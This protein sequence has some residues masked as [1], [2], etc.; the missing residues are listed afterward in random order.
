MYGKQDKPHYTRKLFM[1]N[2]FFVLISLYQL[3]YFWHFTRTKDTFRYVLRRVNCNIL[4]TIVGWPQLETGSHF[5]GKMTMM[6]DE[7][8]WSS[9]MDGFP[10]GISVMWL[11]MVFFC[12]VTIWICVVFGWCVVKSIHFQYARARHFQIGW[13]LKITLNISSAVGIYL[14]KW[15]HAISPH[16]KPTKMNW[17]GDNKIQGSKHKNNY[18]TGRN[19]CIHFH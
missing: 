17:F 9:E 7:H 1:F 10:C 16:Y 6:T 13:L 5:I 3:K 4:R 18:M 19:S 14:A 2:V 15:R 11:P 12:I 8:C